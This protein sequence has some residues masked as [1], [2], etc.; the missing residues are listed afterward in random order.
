M[1]N[2]TERKGGLVLWSPVLTMMGCSFISYVDRQVLAVL[3]PS[4]LRE[5]GL[6]VQNYAEVVGFFSVLYMVGNPVWGV[7]LDRIG[8]RRGM[9]FSVTIWTAASAAH[10][11]LTGFWGFAAARSML[12]FGE[13]ATFPGGLRT[14]TD[15]LPLEKRSRGIAL[16]YSG[17][18]LGAILTPLLVTPIAVAFGWRAAFLFTG[19]LGVGW[20]AVWRRVSRPSI[21]PA[22]ETPGGKTTLPRLTEARFW[23]LV[24]GY[25]LGAFPLSYV[26][27]VAPLYLAKAI[28]YSQAD[29]GKVL[30]LPPLGWETGYF[31]WGWVAD[32][33]AATEMRPAR[34][35]VML[36]VLSLPLA[37]TAQVR[38]VA[39]VLALLFF[40][41]FIAAGFVVLSLRTGTMSY[42]REHT[43][44]VAGI[45]AGSWSAAVALVLPALGRM[46]DRGLFA[47]SF[48]VVSLI[49]IIGAVGWFYFSARSQSVD[50]ILTSDAR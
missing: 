14:A 26:L 35:F 43:A 44:L 3:S 2:S 40:A 45:G 1:S 30:W 50:P 25:A 17:G 32:R 21:L 11:F 33:F 46:F 19:L 13:G 8:L 36:A 10:G 27:Y 9:T 39:V 48:V 5:T 20:L 37:V 22:G 16:A 6:T 15:S 42:P 7:I 31:F 41:M 29:L 4:I 38:N 28:G 18:S 12:G 49:P 47:E 23:A 34:L 24:F